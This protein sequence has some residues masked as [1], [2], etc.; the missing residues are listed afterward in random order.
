MPGPQ[1]TPEAVSAAWAFER[2]KA[3][4]R[5]QLRPDLSLSEVLRPGKHARNLTVRPDG[6][7]S[8]QCRAL[9]TR[10]AYRRESQVPD[11]VSETVDTLDRDQV[12]VDEIHHPV[13]TNS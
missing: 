5:R 2:G 9:S 12:I 7:T 8:A 11:T 6:G 1:V 4:A 13:T 3:P 10:H